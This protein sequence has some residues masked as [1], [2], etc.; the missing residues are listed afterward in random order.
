MDNHALNSVYYCAMTKKKTTTTRK[1]PL[2]Q[3]KKKS[4]VAVKP[5]T[6]TTSKVKSAKSPTPVKKVKKQ[7]KP[8]NDINAEIDK[9]LAGMYEPKTTKRKTQSSNPK[10]TR[11]LSMKELNR[12]IGKMVREALEQ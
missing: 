5:S 1:K 2:T 7:R 11:K 9:I 12:K 4:P 3:K 6:R 10:R 8:K